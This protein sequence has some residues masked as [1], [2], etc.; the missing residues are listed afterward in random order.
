MAATSAKS[1]RITSGVEVITPTV[2]KAW[3]DGQVNIRKVQP[4]T[5]KSYASDI[6]AGRW[7]VTGDSIKFDTDGQLIDGFHRLSGVIEAGKPIESVVVRGLQ[8]EVIHKTD[9]GLRRS[10]I[11]TLTSLGVERASNVGPVARSILIWQRNDAIEGHPSNKFLVPESDVVE[12]AT[13]NADELLDCVREASQIRYH[14][15]ATL[16]S[17]AAFIFLAR[18]VDR[19]DADYFFEALRLGAGLPADSPILA[20]RNWM[21]NRKQVNRTSQEMWAHAYTKSW[22]R[23]RAGEKSPQYL[24]VLILGKGDERTRL[25]ALA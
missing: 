20:L 2:A 7:V 16:T 24:K 17:L 10:M 15:G 22:N 18:Q 11:S 25:D 14:T 12:F 23:F 3:L 4:A 5:Y 8:P 9:K 1:R 6:S 19:T 21:S 13:A